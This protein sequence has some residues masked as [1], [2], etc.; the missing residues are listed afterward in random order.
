MI[1]M[2]GSV[3]LSVKTNAVR[4]LDAKKISYTLYEYDAPDGFLDG[5]S[6][7]TPWKKDFLSFPKE[8]AK[9]SK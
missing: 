9:S 3:Q 6:V 8:S 7:W 2:K 4:M 1:G 5:V